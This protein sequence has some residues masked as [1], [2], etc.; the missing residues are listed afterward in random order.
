MFSP[1]QDLIANSFAAMGNC[2]RKNVLCVK[3]FDSYYSL[4][5]TDYPLDVDSSALL[6]PTSPPSLFVHDPFEKVDIIEEKVFNSID[7]SLEPEFTAFAETPNSIGSFGTPATAS[8]DSI[9]NFEPAYIEL[10]QGANCTGNDF[11]EQEYV[12]YDEINSQSKSICSSPDVDPWMS[13][14]LQMSSFAFAES[15]NALPSINTISNFQS[16][17]FSGLNFTP[18]IID[19]PQDDKILNELCVDAADGF[20]YNIDAPE[21]PNREY[22]CLWSPATIDF[23]DSPI[24]NTNLCDQLPDI[25]K[26]YTPRQQKF[27]KEAVLQCQWESCFQV[28]ESQQTLVGHIEKTHVDVKKAE[29]FS[30]HWV[31][32]TRDRKPFNARYKLLIHMRVHSGEKPNKCQVSEARNAIDRNFSSRSSQP[33]PLRSINKSCLLV[34]TTSIISV[35]TLGIDTCSV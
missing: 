21:K 27:A 26:K 12:N 32:C 13:M 20:N 29:G 6:T 9:F 18:N 11:D 15:A 3:G 1:E 7:G 35:N 33:Q 16:T 4:N 5:K 28:F 24:D 34:Y 19:D 22:K 2:K 23:P 30:C 25:E 17:G 14:Q 31:N 10:I 8:K